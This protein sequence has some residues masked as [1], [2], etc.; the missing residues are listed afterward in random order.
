MGDASFTSYDDESI[1]PITHEAFQLKVQDM[2]F[3]YSK[4]YATWKR[5][6]NGEIKADKRRTVKI[7]EDFTTSV[8][9]LRKRSKDEMSTRELKQRLKADKSP[10]IAVKAAFDNEMKL[11]LRPYVF[12]K[13]TDIGDLFSAKKKPD[14][15]FVKKRDK[16]LNKASLSGIC[17]RQNVLMK[18][19]PGT[20][21]L[22]APNKLYVLDDADIKTIHEFRI[23]GCIDEKTCQIDNQE[24]HLVNKY[25]QET[26]LLFPT[27]N[28]AI[29][30]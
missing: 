5:E 2:K 15:Y 16:R 25:K 26:R 29:R 11:V 6:M 14:D 10:L 13:L 7:L 22:V 8:Q 18:F 30:F 4:T 24:L 23:D 1:D 21:A 19:L 3:E 28:Q 12:K 17:K 9:L 27:A 20:A